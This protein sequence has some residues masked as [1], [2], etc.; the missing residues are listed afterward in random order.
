MYH[1]L[2][3][4][5]IRAWQILHELSEQ[6]ALN[7][8]MAATLASQAHALKG[9]AANVASACSLRRVNLDISK[10]VFESELERQNAQVIIEN[11]TLLQE[12]KQLSAL[13]KEYEETME[14]VMTKFRNHAIAAQQHELTLTRHYE[15]LIQ[16]FDHSLA[17]YD[18]ST[19]TSATLSL[20]RL[21]QSL[22]ALL[23]SISGEHPADSPSQN[24]PHGQHHALS[25][26]VPTPE[27]LDALLQSR[28]DWAIEREAEIARL[29]R[30]NEQLRRTLGIDRASA[31]AN[32]WLEDE[33]RELT[34]RRHIAAPAV[35]RSRRPGQAGI[36]RGNIPLFDGPGQIGMGMGPAPGQ[37]SGPA[38]GPSMGPP[39]QGPGAGPG[40]PVGMPGGSVIQPGMRGV[41]GR[42]LAMFG[43]GR[44]GPPFW[45]GMNQPALERPRQIQ[46]GFDMNR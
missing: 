2:D 21:A 35:Y 4:D 6:N 8:K 38:P 45:D 28:D 20:H 44:G 17:Q 15:T 27:E 10:E 39:G 40:G 7:Q 33:A 41:Q 19:N 5:L 37:G 30:E 36:L 25:S 12:N 43:R 18:L 46:P 22:R 34:V 32:G 31:E 42:R 1:D 23:Y 14:N 11:H 13:L 9:E 24:D 29:E 16:N 26:S 3:G